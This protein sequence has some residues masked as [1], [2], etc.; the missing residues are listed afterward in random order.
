MFY[1]H[2][3]NFSLKSHF[4]TLYHEHQKEIISCLESTQNLCV[5]YHFHTVMTVN[6]VA[7]NQIFQ[8]KFKFISTQLD[9]GV[10]WFFTR[11]TQS[12]SGSARYPAIEQRQ[13]QHRV[14]HV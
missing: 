14:I 4:F 1:F 12:Q 6:K 3:A 10:F 8:K 2:F 5:Q 13:D 7:K 9:G 11:R